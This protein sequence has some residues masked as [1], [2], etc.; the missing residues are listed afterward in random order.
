MKNPLLEKFDQPFGT[1]PFKDI[2]TED[3]VER[4]LFMGSRNETRTS[5]S[6]SLLIFSSFLSY[7]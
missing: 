1:I 6:P 5:G 2:K 7:R 4:T 3:S